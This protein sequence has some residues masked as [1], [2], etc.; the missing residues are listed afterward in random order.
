MCSHSLNNVHTLLPPCMPPGVC[1][2]P[3]GRGRG[4]L[5]RGGMPR[6]GHAK[7][8]QV[9][10]VKLVRGDPYVYGD[11]EESIQN[12]MDIEGQR[13]HARRG[14]CWGRSGCGKGASQEGEASQEG[15]GMQ[16]G[17]RVYICSSSSMN[18]V[19]GY[20]Y[21]PITLWFALKNRWKR[22]FYH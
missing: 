11:K 21:F 15:R 9:G 1:Q 22:H 14:A 13:G 3:S 5:R 12:D 20:P 18:I 4:Y 10:K 16:G 8:C 19:L 17:N 2:G 7:A 6:G